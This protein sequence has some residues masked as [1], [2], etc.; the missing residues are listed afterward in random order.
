[1]PERGAET[2]SVKVLTTAKAPEQA[3]LE[4]DQAAAL[5]ARTR[6]ADSQEAAHNL[7]QD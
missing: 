3:I 1:M 7:F 6:L 2:H 4:G 5:A